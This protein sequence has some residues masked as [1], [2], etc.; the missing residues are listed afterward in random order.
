MRTH[1]TAAFV[2]AQKIIPPYGQPRV[3]YWDSNPKGFGLRV[4]DGGQ[5]TWVLMYRHKGRQRWYTIG[6][7]PPLSLADARQITKD[8]LAD[9]QKGVDPA[10][11]G[12]E[13]RRAA[14][15]LDSFAHL[16]ETYLVKHAREHKKPSSIREDERNIAKELLPI[17]GSRKATEITKA[18]VISL[19][20]D[21]AERPARIH[22]N[23]I[24]ALISKMFNFGIQRDL[25]QSNPAHKV[26][27]PGKERERERTLNDDE[28]LAVWGAIAAEPRHFQVMF[29]V[30]LLTGQRR[31]EVRLMQWSELE[32]KAG[33]WTIPGARTK[34]KRTHRVP[35][36]NE[37]R[38]LL[39]SMRSDGAAGEY[40]FV[41]RFGDGP[42]SSPQKALKRIVERSGVNFTVHDLRRTLAT[43]LGEL[44]FGRT[45]IAKVLNHSEPG[46]TRIYDRHTYD[47][48]KLDALTRWERRL[49]ELVKPADLAAA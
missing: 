45:V 18:D 12:K 36:T 31:S 26:P 5:K 32:M 39:E 29:K 11:R 27:K 46:V 49:M 20:E 40:V 38:A 10:E 47:R 23:R 1:L 35:L 3:T 6:T 13:E 15:G 16:A 44:G 48:E 4:T 22:A 24:L 19:I 33:W 14:A 34:N 9:V 7:Y 17:W 8:K 2:E 37:V 28:L 21:I 30:M 43:G 25:V 41:G 42:L